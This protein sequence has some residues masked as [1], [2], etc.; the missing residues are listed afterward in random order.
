M[1]IPSVSRV[2]APLMALSGIATAA[3]LSVNPSHYYGAS[4][5]LVG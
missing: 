5:N 3:T 4:E 1:N 2:I